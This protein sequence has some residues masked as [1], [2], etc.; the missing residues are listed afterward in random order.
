MPCSISASPIQETFEP[1]SMLNTTLTSAR[2]S[3]SPYAHSP[4]TPDSSIV[5]LDGTYVCLDATALRS[6]PCLS[7]SRPTPDARPST[8]LT[9]IHEIGIQQAA[10]GA[11][12]STKREGFA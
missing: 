1:P 11:F 8:A 10:D 12:L 5:P 6:C 2:R 4:F 7:M 3:S 9:G